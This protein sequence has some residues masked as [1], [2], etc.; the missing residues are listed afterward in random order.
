M[1]KHE[2]DWTDLIGVLC[3]LAFL[4]IVVATWI[5]GIRSV[6]NGSAPETQ[7]VSQAAEPIR[8]YVVNLPGM[9]GMPC[10]NYEGRISDELPADEKAPEESDKGATRKEA[11]HETLPASGD[12]E[13]YAAYTDVMEIVRQNEE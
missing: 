11:N 4:F 2:F 8:V 12:S 3:S 5:V 9:D 6:V 13:E 7:E 1:T 10:E